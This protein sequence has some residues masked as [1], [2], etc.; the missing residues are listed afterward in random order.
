M[1]NVIHVIEHNSNRLRLYVPMCFENALISYSKTIH[2]NYKA[3]F[4]DYW[5]FMRKE[6]TILLIPVMKR[7]QLLKAQESY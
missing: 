1:D 7:G 6:M 2:E 4:I 5:N 3:A